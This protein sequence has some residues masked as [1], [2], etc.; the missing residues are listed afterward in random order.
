MSQRLKAGL[1]WPGFAVSAGEPDDVTPRACACRSPPPLSIRPSSCFRSA[2]SGPPVTALGV[3]QLLNRVA[4]V[5]VSGVP[6]CAPVDSLSSALG[7]GQAT[8]GP[9]GVSRSPMIVSTFRS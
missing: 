3:A 6:R 2:L 4:L 1:S 8:F 9:F 5:S 7:V